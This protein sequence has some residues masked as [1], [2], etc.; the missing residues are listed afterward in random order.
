MPRPESFVPDT[1]N[2]IQIDKMVKSKVDELI[3]DTSEEPEINDEEAAEILAELEKSFQ[4]EEPNIVQGPEK[5][6]NPENEYQP[7]WFRM[8]FPKLFPD[9]K[10]DITCSRPGKKVSLHKWL[11]HLLRCDRR[12]ANDPLFVM[13]TTN[14]IQK[15]EALNLGSLYASKK[16][17][18]LT[19]EDL[20][21]CE[22]SKTSTNNEPRTRYVQ[23]VSNI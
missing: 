8:A 7:G 22:L 1:G 2:K 20:K 12:F 6:L 16:A 19:T 23:S 4:E 9:G 15:R 21:K 17:S 18:E 10:G 11:K 5:G 14:M 13:V 3:K